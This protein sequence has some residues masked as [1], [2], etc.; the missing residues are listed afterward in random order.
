MYGMYVWFPEPFYESWTLYGWRGESGDSLIVWSLIPEQFGMWVGMFLV[1]AFS[2]SLDVAAIEMELGLPLDYNKLVTWL[3]TESYHCITYTCIHSSFFMFFMFYIVCFLFFVF[4][5]LFFTFLLR[6][7]LYTVGL[8]NV[9]SGLLG[10][11][12]GSYIFSQTIFTMRRGVSTR[13]CGYTVA[14][15]ELAVILLPISITSYV[16]K[17]FFGSLLVLISIDLLIEWLVG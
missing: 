8:S 16:P 6:R 15:C 11:Y 13:I 12:T 14:V 3:L 4:A 2:S 7:E 17:M 9:F 1:V 10:G 5:F